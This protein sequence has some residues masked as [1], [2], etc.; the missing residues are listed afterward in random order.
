LKNIRHPEVMSFLK[1][2]L[3]HLRKGFVLL[4]DRGS[5]HKAKAIKKF[6]KGHPHI[7]SHFFPGYAPELN[8]DEFVWTNM[9]RSAANSVP[10]DTND[11]KNFLKISA[12]I[13]RRSEGLLWSCIHAS[14]L[15]WD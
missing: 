13:L 6:L 14:E 10:K 4:W 11:L 9:K 1:H 8:P 3:R 5:T 15:P 2:L 12:Q 7:H